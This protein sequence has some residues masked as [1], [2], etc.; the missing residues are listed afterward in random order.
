MPA[1]R[2]KE[3]SNSNSLASVLPLLLVWGGAPY[4][5]FIF[6]F[7]QLQPVFCDV[8]F[9]SDERNLDRLHVFP[10]LF[11]PLG[12]PVH[13]K[14]YLLHSVCQRTFPGCLAT[15]RAI[16]LRRSA[17]SFTKAGSYPKALA[18]SRAVPFERLIRFALHRLLVDRSIHLWWSSPA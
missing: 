18:A 11:Q 16:S 4:H 12:L 1:S 14:R 8:Y 9:A 6:L 15:R 13:V 3:R 2:K 17:I 5:P 10:Q 7:L